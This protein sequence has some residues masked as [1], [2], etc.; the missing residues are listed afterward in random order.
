V[1]G[2][3]AAGV[4]LHVTSLPGG[5]LGD[6]AYRFVDWLQAAGQ[7]WW[8]ILPITPPDAGGSP[9]SS[10]SAFAGWPG[11]LADPEAPVAVR[12]IH[13]F[14]ARHADWVPAW[15]AFAGPGA[16]ADQVRFARE[17]H[18]LREYAAERGIR[19]IGDLPIYVAPD[20]CDVHDHPELF[21]AG[22]L[23]GAPPDT[24]SRDGQLWGNPVYN[25]PAHRADGYRWW[26][27]RM[28]RMADFC[29]VVRIDHFRGF[30][31]GWEIPA[32]APNAA[33]GRWRRGPGR[34][35]FD[36]MTAELGPLPVIAEDLGR[37]TPAVTG[38][39]DAL[40][41]PGMVVLIWAFAHGASNPY[42]PD[43]HPEHAV[44][45]TGTHDTPTI[46]EWWSDVA[47]DAERAEADHQA[48]RR[49]IADPDPAWRM[50]RLALASRARLAI[51]PA[52]DLLGL[53][54]EARM[55]RPGTDTGNWRWRLGENAL[56]PGLAARLRAA[57]L[58]AGRLVAAE[59]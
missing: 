23:A 3:R 41:Y 15:E 59:D 11:L 32:G 52:Q 46:A 17:W 30:V 58:A 21:R 19:I 29:D 20:S 12:D 43:N 4:L 18:A 49:G 26:I 57:T 10:P 24:L 37:I 55:N 14:R 44:A 31:S 9:Y 16:V 56:D 25:W 40:G 36:A 47:T 50:V 22:I 42:A 27:A 53:G 45:Y 28:R 13:R 48:A 6:A 5:R 38:L 39:R 54:R 33:D 51:I 2:P 34:A 7:S 8:Q 1:I 35:V